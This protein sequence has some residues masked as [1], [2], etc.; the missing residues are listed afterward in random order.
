LPPGHDRYPRRRPRSARP[1][2]DPPTAA[3]RQGRGWSLGDRSRAAL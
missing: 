2:L 1:L 3:A